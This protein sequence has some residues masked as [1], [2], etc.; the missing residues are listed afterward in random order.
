MIP[1]D[2]GQ[3]SWRHYGNATAFTGT[4]AETFDQSTK[5]TDQIYGF[6]LAGT[7]SLSFQT[8]CT[9]LADQYTNSDLS[10]VLESV[11]VLAE[12]VALPANTGV[13]DPYAATSV[14]FVRPPHPFA[15]LIRT[16]HN[17]AL[18]RRTVAE[19]TFLRYFQDV[20]KAQLP[21]E[22]AIEISRVAG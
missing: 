1:L 17:V 22:A 11:V 7:T 19:S 3:V 10:E 18:S 21:V 2:R 13:S 9:R 6:A 8:L 12:G 20:D 14:S 5:G 15:H 4:L 16:L